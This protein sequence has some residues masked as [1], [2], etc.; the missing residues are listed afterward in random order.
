MSTATVSNDA[1]SKDARSYRLTNIDML[2]GL[3]VIIMAIDHVRDFFMVAGV[4]DPMA[5]PNI[6]TGLFLTR[7]VTHFCAPV[8]V[9]L[10]GTSAGLMATR[11]SKSE[12]GGFL[13]KRGL[14]L[15]FVEVA[16]I[17]MGWT[18]SPFGIEAVGGNSM[19]FL[20]VIW[21]IGVAMVALAG[22][23][24]LGARGCLI[25]AAIILLGSNLVDGYWPLG[26]FLGGA[27]AWWYGFF[28]QGSFVAGDFLLIS[29]YPIVPWIG[30]MA[31]GYATA[32]IFQKE[33]GERDRYLIKTGFIM[34][35]AFIVIRALDFYGD[36]N[37]WMHHEE[38]LVAT[39]FGFM[40]VTKYPPS[41]VFL[42]ATLGPMAIFCGYADRMSGWWKDMLVMFGRVPFAFYVL[43]IYLIH[44]MAIALG[45]AQGYE[46]SRLFNV[47]FFFPAG[48]G[49]TLPYVYVGWV[50]VI[51]ALYPLC[52]WMADL[53]TRRRDWWLSYL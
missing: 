41:L 52:K 6:T 9:F 12:L 13:L 22:L 25:V 48:Y 19:I 38:G 50:L 39:F 15:I 2:R 40:N 18:F 10:A 28:S 36:P 49:V 44:V 35:A 4:Q 31:L 53:K 45:V 42:L 33:A 17:S 3:V 51:A 30:V 23:Q 43:H 46:V 7:W 34:I 8:F 21:A 32:N 24:Y 20:Q 29:V 16:I 27:D 14:W 47:F 11:K 5:D 26:S 1:A 37:P